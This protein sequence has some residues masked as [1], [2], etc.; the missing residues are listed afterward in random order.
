MRQSVFSS[1]HS[2][3]LYIFTTVFYSSLFINHPEHPI[4]LALE[5]FS[6]FDGGESESI[7]KK[8]DTRSMPTL[9]FTVYLFTNKLSVHVPFFLFFCQS[10][11]RACLPPAQ[12]LLYPTSHPV[13]TCTCQYSNTVHSNLLTP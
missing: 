12:M 2:V 11:L 8:T 13:H 9:R 1:F 10:L 4:Y 3:V 6:N 5:I 7:S